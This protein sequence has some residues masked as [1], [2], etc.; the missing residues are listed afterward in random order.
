MSS[1]VKRLIR[2]FGYGKSQRWSGQTA[3]AAACAAMLEHAHPGGRWCINC[4]WKLIWNP[5]RQKPSSQ[6][7]VRRL[8]PGCLYRWVISLNN[9][10]HTNLS[11]SSESCFGKS[12]WSI[13]PRN[14]CTSS[15]GRRK[16][17][18]SLLRFFRTLCTDTH[19]AA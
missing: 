4:H 13:S 2:Y 15:A 18:G 19:T 3:A 9:P 17:S 5:C 10:L 16:T 14:G 12:V 6:Y 8:K 7:R 11:P 1:I